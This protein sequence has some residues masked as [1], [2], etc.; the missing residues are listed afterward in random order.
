MD[1]GAEVAAIEA[2]APQRRALLWHVLDEV[3][4]S[5][6]P[7]CT[8]LTGAAVNFALSLLWLAAVPLT[9]RRHSDWAIVVGTYFAVFILADVTTT[10]LLGADAVRVRD[11]LLREV[12]LR[13]ILL[14]KNLALLM[15]V[16]LPTALAT[17]LVTV[18][19][20]DGYRLVLTIPGVAFPILTWLG[21]GNIVSVSMPVAV[22]SLRKRWQQRHQGRTTVRWLVHLALPYALLDAVEPI[23]D[24][25]DAIIG[26]LHK[27]PRTAET[28]GLVLVLTGLALWALG[29]AT[30]LGIVR[31]HRLRIR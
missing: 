27:L 23:G 15:I 31:V 19:S 8:W 20:E 28:H 12:P 7:P 16:G 17:V 9:G 14:V 22:V 1:H 2:R 4:W 29:S 24:L 21:V 25:P 26:H 13:R 30:A 11:A 18:N 6:T 10:N 3:R 5:F